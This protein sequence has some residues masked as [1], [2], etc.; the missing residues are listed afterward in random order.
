MQTKEFFPLTGLCIIQSG[1]AKDS[2]ERVK[3]LFKAI[4]R[5]PV[6]TL[7]LMKGRYHA[8]AIMR[9]QAPVYLE[10]GSGSKR[11]SNGWKTL[12]MSPDCD[13][14]WDLSK[15][16]PFKDN[17]IDKIYSSHLL[18]HFSPNAGRLLLNECYRCI[19]PGGKITV[20]VP[21]ARIYINAYVQ[22]K[23]LDYEYLSHR[24][25]VHGNA[26]I[27]MVNYIA[28]MDGH[29]FTLFDEDGLL[30]V[31]EEAGFSSVSLREY[32][33]ELDPHDRRHNSIYAE[34]I[35]S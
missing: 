4:F 28:Y 20:S 13:I 30:E 11:G 6:K 22:N 32:D 10:I 15:G 12:D 3:I 19:K 33:Q 31:L 8:R 9:S 23:R 35:K 16:I 34:G 1:F 26:P 14:Y 25:A 2:G 27:S 5:T 21:N 17:L 7:R 24:P 29:H 18:E